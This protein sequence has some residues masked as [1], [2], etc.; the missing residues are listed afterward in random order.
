MAGNLAEMKMVLT[1][2]NDM[3]MLGFRMTMVRHSYV[4]TCAYVFH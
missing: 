3:P 1:K 4:C 2:V